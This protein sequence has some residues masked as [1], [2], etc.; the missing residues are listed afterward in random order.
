MTASLVPSTRWAFEFLERLVRRGITDVV[1]SPGSRSQALSLAAASL[2]STGVLSVHVRVDERTAGFLA[3]GIALE[4]RRPVVVVCTSGSSVANL[5]PAV[6][7]AH[8]AGVPLIVVTADRPVE[9]RT[10]GVNQTTVQPG[11]FATAVARVWDFDASVPDAAGHGAIIADEALAAALTER[12]PVHINPQ[13]REPLSSAIPLDL[14]RTVRPGVLPELSPASSEIN[15]MV[16]PGTVVVAG[17]GAGARAEQWARE[18]GAPLIA[19]VNS[20]AHFGPHLV[21]AY[22]DILNSPEF[23]QNISSVIVVGRPTLSREID[24][25][26]RSESLEVIVVRGPEAYPY[27]PRP[28]TLVVDNIVPVGD[29]TS[30]SREWALPWARRSRMALDIAFPEPSLD[31]DASMAEDHRTRSQFARQEMDVQREK[32]TPQLLVKAVWDATWPH[33]RLVFGA[34]SLIRVADS[35]VPGKPLKVSSNRGLNGIDGT[36]A[37]AAGIALGSQR[38]SS[39][40]A[41]GMTRVVLG[42]LAAL[43][44]IA[45]LVGVTS[46]MQVIVGNNHGGR[47]F[48]DLEV[49]QTAGEEIFERVMLTPQ[50]LDFGKIA[51]GFGWEYRRVTTRGQLTEAL[52]ITHSRVVIEVELP[53]SA[54]DGI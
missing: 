40:D 42:D 14:V 27:R 13:F 48:E 36:I 33:D 38:P 49:A 9:L 43:Y 50:I 53:H 26:C 39:I 15:V 20:G 23:R 1:V 3:L 35:V 11:M 16:L 2:E 29:P 30:L 24:A 5:H 44:D 18:L 51:E 41:H 8:H 45:G 47:I 17:A 25:L 52:A 22:R 21:T 28:T 19:E 7:E 12:S 46:R 4:T 10:A 54:A 37:T 32:I 31:I 6:L 34:S